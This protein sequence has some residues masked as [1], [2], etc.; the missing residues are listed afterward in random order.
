MGPRWKDFLERTGANNGRTGSPVSHQIQLRV[1]LNPAYAPSI[2]KANSL[3]SLSPSSSVALMPFSLISQ[4]IILLLFSK[5]ALVTWLTD[6]ITSDKRGCKLSFESMFNLSASRKVMKFS[7]ASNICD[8]DAVEPCCFC[9]LWSIWTAVGSAMVI[10][11]LTR[12][13]SDARGHSICV[14]K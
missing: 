11:R 3:A 13:R 6:W 4:L 8:P 9:G 10:G 1:A 14:S 12:I 2:S 5:S 7:V